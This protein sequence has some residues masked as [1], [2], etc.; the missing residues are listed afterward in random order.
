MFSKF[1]KYKKITTDRLILEVLDSRYVLP[2]LNFLESGRDCFEKYESLK[3]GF[4][5]TESF[6]SHI[7]SREYEASKRGTYLR[8]Y[9][10][11]KDRPDKIIGTVSFGNV[12]PDPYQCCNAGYK[13][14]PEHQGKGYGTEALKAA[15]DAAF[16]YLSVHRMN[17]FVMEDNYASIRILEKCGFEKEGKCIKNLCVKGKWTDHLL[18]AIINPFWDRK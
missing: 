13:I 2:V 18:Y 15:M 11:E 6:Q 17:A 7:L 9:I 1:D 5:Y 12:L 3:S 16:Y 14:S 4:Y 10:F 8:Y